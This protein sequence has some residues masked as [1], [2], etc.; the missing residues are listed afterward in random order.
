MHTLNELLEINNKYVTKE[1]LERFF[2]QQVIN[3][4]K[5][6]QVIERAVDIMKEVKYGA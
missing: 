5:D 2:K 1:V 4:I 6:H 3:G